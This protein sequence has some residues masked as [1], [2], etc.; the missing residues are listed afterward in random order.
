MHLSFDLVERLDFTLPDFTRFSWVSEEARRVWEPRLKRISAAW[1]DVEWLSVLAGV[2][3]CSLALLSQEAVARTAARWASHGLSMLPL[4]TAAAPDQPYS[5]TLRQPE[6]GKPTV[7]RVV[8]GTLEN[9]ARFK[10]AWDAGS[11]ETK[12]LLLGYPPCCRSFFQQVWVEQHYVD[13]TWAMATNTV[14]ARNGRALIEQSGSP[15]ANILWRWMGVRAVPHLPCSF[16]CHATAEL[17]ERLLQVGRQEGYEREMDWISQILSWSVEWSALHGIA[18]IKTPVLK[19]ST[20][21]DATAQK[22][23]VRWQGVAAPEERVAGLEFPY[24]LPAR[25]FVTASPAFQRGLDN[26]IQIKK[27]RPAWYH[28]DNGFS[29]RHQMK[30]L[31]EPIVTLARRELA[32]VQGDI[33]DLGC[34]NAALLEKICKEKEGLIPHGIDIKSDSL[35]HARELLPRFAGNFVQGN[36]FDAAVWAKSRR[37]ALA[38]LMIGRLLE[39]PEEKAN[40]LREVL[41]MRC[42]RVLVYVYA[43]WSPDSLETL[44]HRAGLSL[45]KEV[46]APVGL[47][48]MS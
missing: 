40:Q 25:S 2:R 21:T 39:V 27:S 24:E 42:D 3:L 14:R 36:L 4:Q 16:A 9:V 41:K 23:V 48:M 5:S 45:R 8:V 30:L 1:F 28:L 15:G 35:A 43:G 32:D 10:E 31:H 34:G 18:E 46:S 7:Q 6:P 20:R 37:Y 26:L 22:Y 44:T 38:I 29:S 17:G 12:G 11:H 13:T 19:V 33:I 47:A